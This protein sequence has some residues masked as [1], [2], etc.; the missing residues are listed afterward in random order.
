MTSSDPWLQ[1]ARTV[2]D[3]PGLARAAAASRPTSQEFGT[4][5]AA[6]PPSDQVRG[7]IRGARDNWN[8]CS[9]RM[10]GASIIPTAPIGLQ[11]CTASFMQLHLRLVTSAFPGALSA[12]CAPQRA[13]TARG[14][15]QQLG[16]AP[17]FYFTY[18]YPVP[19]FYF[20]YKYG[21][22]EPRCHWPAIDDP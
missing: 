12:S 19:I 18:K 10:H 16:A 21:V 17:I 20:T 4:Q 14:R 6:P 3:S 9:S 1:G 11:L 13:G 5:G 15:E 8:L 2:L 7:G 22:L